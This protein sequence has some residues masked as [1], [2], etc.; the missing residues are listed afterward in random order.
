MY[1]LTLQ[2][3]FDIRLKVEIERSVNYQ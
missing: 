2:F 1:T 3:I